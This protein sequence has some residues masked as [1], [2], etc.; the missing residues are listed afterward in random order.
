MD[1]IQL[2]FWI[3]VIVLMLVVEAAT[4]SFVSLWFAGGA[5]AA[6]IAGLLGASLLWQFVL[7]LSVSAILLACLYPL[8]K[9]LLRRRPHTATNLDRVIGMT[10]PVTETIDNIE[11]TGAVRADGKVWSARSTDGTVIEAGTLVAVD[12][13]EGVRLYVTPLKEERK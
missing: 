9:K 10:A 5:L 8:A 6:L 7:F 11:G 1:P 12:R 2:I 3:A 13:I 4:V